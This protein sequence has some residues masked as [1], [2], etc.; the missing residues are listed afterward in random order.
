M[1]KYK[2]NQIRR[3]R[4]V[5]KGGAT[6]PLIKPF[7]Y[8]F[9][10]LSL[11]VLFEN[12][13]EFKDNMK[14]FFSPEQTARNHDIT[15]PE[16]YIF[17][18]NKIMKYTFELAS[19]GRMEMF[20]PLPLCSIQKGKINRMISTGSL[21][22]IMAASLVSYP[23][24]QP[25]EI[26]GDNYVSGFPGLISNPAHLYRT[27]ADDIFSIS[28]NN[29]EEL[30]IPEGVYNDYYSTSLQASEKLLQDSSPYLEPG[31]NLILD[32]SETEYKFDK[33]FNSTLKASQLLLT[34]I[35]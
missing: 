14:R 21:G 19:S 10:L 6:T 12:S 23:D 9:F 5:Q 30:Q 28:I 34:K 33:I 16:K 2:R 15:F 22:K 18:N 31:R 17:N 3:L 27:E 1:K 29:R 4:K 24:Y 11:F 7:S 25:V 8:S 13:S 20:N 26:N 32:V 35:I